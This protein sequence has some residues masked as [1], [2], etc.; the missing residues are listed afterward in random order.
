VV[1]VPTLSMARPKLAATAVLGGGGEIQVAWVQVLD[2]AG[3]R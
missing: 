2:G 1:K 3:Q